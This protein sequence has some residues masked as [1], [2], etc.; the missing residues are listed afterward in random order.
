MAKN[1]IAASDA[2]KQGIVGKAVVYGVMAA[3]DGIT[4]IL[5][6]VSVVLD[7]VFPPL[8]PIIDLVSTI[9]Q[10]INTILGFF[11]DLI[12]FR[13]T[14]QRVHDEFETYINSEAFKTYVN[15]MAEGYKNRGF[16]IF[17]YYVD[18][19]VAGI[20]ADKETLQAE[21][22]TITKCLTEKAKEDF[23]NKQLR[24]ALVDATSFG[25][26]LKGRAN[27]DEIVAGFGPDRIYGEEGDDILFGRGGSDT[28]Y[29]GPGNDYLNG[30]T[31]RDTLFGGEGDDF[32]VCEP[33]VDRRCEG[34]GGDD[35]L[36]LS[37]ESLRFKESLWN[38]RY[39]TMGPVWESMYQR[40]P[41]KSP[42]KGIYLDI[43]YT[44]GSGSNAKK[45]RT[46]ITLGSC[47]PGWPDGFNQV[48]H[49]PAFL[50]SSSLEQSL[51]NFFNRK[52]PV[53]LSN[54]EELKS[55]IL[56]FLAEKSGLKYFCDGISLYAV[57]TSST[58]VARNAINSISQSSAIY[59]DGRLQYSGNN[60][61]E[62]LLAF[63]FRRSFVFDEFEKIAAAQPD[64]LDI[65]SHYIP[66]TIIGSDEHN[67][68][69]VSYGL[70]DVVYTGEGNNVISIGSTINNYKV[71]EDSERV[72]FGFYNWA[73]YI[74]GGS[75]E[76]TLVIQYTSLPARGSTQNDY[77]GRWHLRNIDN[78]V[79]KGDFPRYYTHVFYLKNIPTVEV[80]QPEARRNYH[81]EI[82]IDAR[83][84]DGARRYILNH[85]DSFSDPLSTEKDVTVLP[86]RLVNGYRGYSIRFGEGTK[87][88][89]SFKYYEDERYQIDTINIH[90]YQKYKYEE[91]YITFRPQFGRL[92]L[93]HA[94]NVVS[95]PS[96]K[97]IIGNDKENLLIAVGGETN[98]DAKDGDDTLVS[99]RG[100]HELIG[101][102][103]TDSYVLHGPEVVD[104]L[105]ISV[106]MGDDGNTIRCKTTIYGKWMETDGRLEIDILKHDHAD[107]LL[108]TVEII[109][110]EDDAGKNLGTI[111]RDHSNR[112][113]IYQP[114]SNFNSLKRNQAKVLRVSY[115]TM[116][117]IATINEGD[118][119]NQLR[120]E[121]IRSLDHLAASVED[122]KLVF[123][124]KSNP[125]RTVFID[126]EWGN[127]L[128]S[129]I[130]TNLFDLIID[131]AQRFP[132]MLFR[133]NDQEFNRATAK[134]T[135]TFLYEQLKHLEIALG[136]E[137]DTILD[138]TSL[139]STVGNEIDVGN[140]QNI[141][142]AKTRGK[143]YKLGRKSSGSIIVANK[144]TQGTGKSTITG[145]DD[146]NS[147][148]AVVVGVGSGGVVEIFHMGPH[149]VIVTDAPPNEVQFYRD[150]DDKI[151]L[152]DSQQ[153]DLIKGWSTGNCK[154]LIFKKSENTQIIVN[155]Q[156][157]ISGRI[158]SFVQ[159]Y[160]IIVSYGA[161]KQL[162][163]NL[164]F[165][166]TDATI[167]F[168][169][170]YNPRGKF[171]WVFFTEPYPPISYSA[172]RQPYLLI[173]AGYTYPTKLDAHM[174]A[175]AIRFQF[176]AGIQF[177]DELVK[178]DK[179]CP[180]VIE[181]FKSSPPRGY[182]LTNLDK[183]C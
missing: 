63:A 10:V 79:R 47:F 172:V 73:K 144:F 26:T 160:P 120:F 55:K 36:A 54:A 107:V 49:T 16:D 64:R 93:V 159:E 131:F 158:Y 105:T 13:T 149:D 86:R 88:T 181:K 84:Y 124:D 119:G 90:V 121:S 58:R 57:S 97:N 30:G 85:A 100:R 167:D 140:G 38:R 92:W 115:T 34:E 122:D 182:E 138:S 139:P 126:N 56:W 155:C 110:A 178:D 117:S 62:A 43:G 111:S 61:L 171:L 78:P 9:L 21:R 142:L 8:S 132:L 103:G 161:D 96:Y 134:Q 170:P 35:T 27:D 166:K 12:D 11:A 14:A 2:A 168:Y 129:G 136:Q 127:K 98:V 91:G 52:N 41:R 109:P 148:N 44:S 104:Y 179:I 116:G 101:G 75:G 180:F 150:S 112:K 32:L 157:Y 82:S 22:K 151:C 153:R 77:Y 87:N 173:P 183:E 76:N 59:R 164:P 23:E 174:L 114:G 89:I 15:N 45:G 123:K 33:G 162:K 69:D 37:G 46:G 175:N 169:Y 71:T 5:D 1:A 95:F 102:P 125:P 50:P 141:V 176:K 48:I 24:V 145:G 51:V 60:E 108:S 4:A 130:S 42:V 66:T 72:T 128:K 3:V 146:R 163:L 154:R 70:G 135:I 81:Q 106:V 147:L 74:V 68:I 99:T 94:M 80:R 156:E 18:A 113:I 20:E 83:Y 118:D 53:T 67:V 31:G 28:I 177:S 7:F 143:T 17:K 133:K 19:D 29:G 165:K 25:K 6:G 137:L 39:I 65:L 40:N 152:K